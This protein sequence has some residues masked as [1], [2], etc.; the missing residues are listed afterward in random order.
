VNK[1]ELVTRM[2]R[3]SGLTKADSLRALDAF[4]ALVMRALKK[5]VRVKIA[6]F[7][8][9]AISRRKARVVLNPRSGAPV[10]IPSR[11]APRFTPSKELKATLAGGSR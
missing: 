2:A 11:R 1:A 4:T 6:G 3:E 10:K 7:G 9:F 5:G 8:T